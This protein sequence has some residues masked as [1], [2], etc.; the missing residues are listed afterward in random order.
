MDLVAALALV[1]VLEGMALAVFARSIPQLLA[2]MDQIS[3]ESLR[4]MGILAVIAGAVLY[5]W[6]R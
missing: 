2:E 4:R 3:P 5:V 1:L 6:I